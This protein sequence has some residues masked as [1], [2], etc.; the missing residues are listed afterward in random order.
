M[1][2]SGIALHLGK[3]GVKLPIPDIYLRPTDRQFPLKVGSI[4]FRDLPGAEVNDKMK[5]MIDVAFGEPGICEG[6]PMLETLKGMLD[7]VGHIVTD[8]T[9]LF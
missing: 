1:I 3:P 7:L 2:K 9:P 6:E 8:F 5:F 4:L